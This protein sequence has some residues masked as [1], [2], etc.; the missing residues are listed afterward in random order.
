M[1]S[2]SQER[3]AKLDNLAELIKQHELTDLIFICTHNSR[4][5]QFAQVAFQIACH[6]Q[7]LT[8]DVYSGGTEETSLNENALNAML[9][10]GIKIEKSDY[11]SENREANPI[12]I[13]DVGE[14][15]I[16]LFSKKYDHEINPQIDFL[17]V[18]VCEEADA[19]CPYVPGAKARY[20]LPYQ[21]PKHSDG[22]ENT[23]EVYSE[24]FK[25]ISREMNYL[26]EQIAKK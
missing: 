8:I 22:S 19:D 2:I 23:A 5:S 6:E 3:I 7:S 16:K 4:R 9:E 11:D 20:A 12:Y 26:A 10:A 21:D 18:M 14:K 1:K 15:S 24:S 13:L 17:A 25:V